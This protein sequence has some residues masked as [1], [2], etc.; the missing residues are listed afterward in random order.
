MIMKKKDLA[1]TASVKADIRAVP[2][3]EL[4]EKAV[5]RKFTA[6]YKP[7]ILKEAEFCSKL[8]QL[9]A[10]LGRKGLYHSSLTRSR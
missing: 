2:D 4:T 3:P 9:R 8:G 5:R 10:L 7:R 6:K 1:V